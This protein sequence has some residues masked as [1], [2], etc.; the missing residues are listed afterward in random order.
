MEP[1]KDYESFSGLEYDEARHA[2]IIDDRN[3]CQV[4]VFIC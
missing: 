2:N 4:R 3:L 1:V